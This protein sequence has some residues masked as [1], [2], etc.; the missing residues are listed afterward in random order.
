M[1]AMEALIQAILALGLSSESNERQM[2]KMQRK[3]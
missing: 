2:G 1:T 3:F